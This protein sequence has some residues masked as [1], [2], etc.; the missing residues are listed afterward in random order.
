MSEEEEERKEKKKEE[1]NK[2]S[3]LLWNVT[4]GVT[5]KL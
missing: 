1:D 2:I 4:F 3:P 5:N